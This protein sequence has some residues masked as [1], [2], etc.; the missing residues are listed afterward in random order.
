LVRVPAVAT[1][2]QWTLVWTGRAPVTSSN[3]LQARYVWEHACAALKADPS[4]EGGELI[5]ER[6]LILIASMLSDSLL[7]PLAVVAVQQELLAHVS[8]GLI[9][10]AEQLIDEALNSINLR[11]AMLQTPQA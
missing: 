6:E 9:A 3:P 5:L 10:S 4:A 7:T 2:D 8:A 1:L 11:A